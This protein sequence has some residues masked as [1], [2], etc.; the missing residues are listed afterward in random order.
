M[1]KY[2][3]VLALIVVAVL[4]VTGLVV[5][6]PAQAAVT[7][8]QAYVTALYADYLGRVPS[9]AESDGWVKQLKTSAPNRIIAD[10]FVNSDEYR[11]IR[12][13]AA[14]ESVLGRESEPAGRRTWLNGM[15]GGA[16]TT[17]DIEKEFYAS[18]EFFFGHGGTNKRFAAALYNA[19]LHRTGTNSEW[20]FWGDLAAKNGRAWV[21][22]QFWDSSETISSRVKAMYT[23]Y[24]GRAPDAAGL[25]T[26]VNVALAIGDSGLRSGFTSS[27]EYYQ[28]SYL[29][30]GG[31]AP[32]PTPTP[33][34]TFTPKPTPTPTPKPTPTPTPKPTPI[35]TPTP[36]P[37]PK[38]TPT[39]TPTPTPEPPIAA[40]IERGSTATGVA[41]TSYLDSIPDYGFVRWTVGDDALQRD[42]IP[43]VLF[44]HGS[45]GKSDA[46][47]HGAEWQGLRDYLVNNGWAFIEGTGGPTTE[48]GE[49]TWGNQTSRNAYLAYVDHVEG[50]ISV[51][52]IVPL[53]RSMG[54]ITADWLY[55]K[56]PIAD[57]CMGLIVNSGVQTLSFGTIGAKRSNDRPTID[58]FNRVMSPAYDADSIEDLAELS[59]PF[60]PY[61]L[62]ASA[63]DGARVLQLVGDNDTI[64]SPDTRG[65][66]PLRAKYA[67]HP[68]IDRL[69]VRAGGDHSAANGSAL[70]LGA[71]TKFLYDV[72]R[73]G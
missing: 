49:Q 46:F 2:R 45:G 13:D 11:L 17:D 54:G 72:R 53:G 16:L 6:S 30:F 50:K 15:R 19:L 48:A 63:W 47:T 67:G 35:P 5:S 60:D 33:T 20:S 51:G 18:T 26:W 23:L 44:V 68:E 66:Y 62:P 70:Q 32:V 38:P 25:R 41:Y 52:G 59:A 36:T 28:R 57:Q 73:L 40:A 4:G 3:A 69:D 14:Y 24:L 55:L 12:I 7:T 27:Q 31:T 22:D 58:Y 65:A 42:D 71:M 37:T 61:N 9:A 39:P 29:R 21:I 64:V 1:Q 34:P 56:S 10:G 8:K 43:T